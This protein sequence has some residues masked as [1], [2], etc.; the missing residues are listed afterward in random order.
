MKLFIAAML[1]SS[2]VSPAVAGDSRNEFCTS[3]SGFARE[4]M[5]SRQMGAP[6]S[7]MIELMKD[8]QES[9]PG[10]DD[11]APNT[12][13]LIIAAY[14]QTRWNSERGQQ[15]AI[16]NFENDVHLGCMRGKREEAE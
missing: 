9:E 6:M 15:R 8:V 13:K 2:L 10:G 3:V 4:L 1:A 11:I 7:K 16:E 5:R 14:E 12:L